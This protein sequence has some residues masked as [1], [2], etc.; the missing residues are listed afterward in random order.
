MAEPP[1]L[2]P[3]PTPTEAHTLVAAKYARPL[4]REIP[5]L[6]AARFFVQ[7]HIVAFHYADSTWGQ[8]WVP[9]F[10][11][12]SGFGPAYSHLL[13]RSTTPP[14]T[15]LPI[16]ATLAR[17]LASVYPTYVV[18]ILIAVAYDMLSNDAPFR[19]LYF[20]TQM[21]LVNTWIPFGLSVRLDYDVQ[22]EYNY[23]GWYISTLALLWL[24]ENLAVALAVALFRHGRASAWP[25]VVAQVAFLT[26]VL[27]SPFGGFQPT[28]WTHGPWATVALKYLHY[29][30]LGAILAAAVHAR[31]AN[32]AA[33][34]RW[35][36]TVGAAV[37]ALIFCLPVDRAWAR[38]WCK[39]GPGLLSP[40]HALLVVG[41][42]EAPHNPPSWSA[43]P[44]ARLLGQWP[45]P[46]LGELALGTYILQV[47]A[48]YILLTLYDLAGRDVVVWGSVPYSAPG[49]LLVHFA[50]LTG[51]AALVHYAVQKPVG[52]GMVVAYEALAA[53][54]CS[55]CG[56]HGGNSAGARQQSKDVAS[57]S[58]R[59]EG[60]TTHEQLAPAARYGTA[61]GVV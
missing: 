17:R 44:L 50:F 29:Y 28:P 49:P 2:L 6:N 10:C 21:L 11:I 35:L 58:S 36:A 42:A 59:S 51:L 9:F 20:A 18:G 43:E 60:S 37:L 27:A 33:A 22:D 52:K 38:E 5:S 30:F 57:T 23:P 13:K 26:W 3:S 45:L 41:F 48:R 56:P 16:P 24:F 55:C 32:G 54:C 40:L 19:P 46:R 61:G 4:P 1:P 8:T 12:V 39:E 47:P 31:A 7:L 14:A 25:W 15:F 34:I 53:A